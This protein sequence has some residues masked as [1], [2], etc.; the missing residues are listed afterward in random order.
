LQIASVVPY[1]GFKTADGDIFIGGANDRLFGIMCDKLGRPEWKTSPK[2]K[3]NRDRVRHRAELE[4]LI[5]AETQKRPT[6]EWLHVFDGSGMPYAAVNDVMDT[7]EHEHG[8][9]AT[10]QLISLYFPSPLLF[11][12]LTPRDL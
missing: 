2:F 12:F 9:S 6:K 10:S 1:Q 7:L 4:P 3:T 5:E 8:T 11:L